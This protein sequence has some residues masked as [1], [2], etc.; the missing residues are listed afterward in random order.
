M[1]MIGQFFLSFP[2]V[3]FVFSI[4]M[5]DFDHL[6]TNMYWQEEWMLRRNHFS[7]REKPLH[8]DKQLLGQIPAII[9]TKKSNVI[10]QTQDNSTYRTL[11]D[12]DRS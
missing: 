5:I 9:A 4:S 1:S 8:F 10:F 12:E 2:I 7:N 6:L 11:P 3:E